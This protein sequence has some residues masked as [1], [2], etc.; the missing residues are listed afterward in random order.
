MFENKRI[1]RLFCVDFHS[2]RNFW[3]EKFSKKEFRKK[4]FEWFSGQ[5]KARCQRDDFALQGNCKFLNFRLS[6]EI[7]NF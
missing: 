4:F 7:Q 3:E 2:K 1:F 6:K 5:I